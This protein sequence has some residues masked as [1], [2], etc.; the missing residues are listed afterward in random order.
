MNNPRL[1]GRYAKSLLDLAVENNELEKVYADIKYIK[2]LCRQNPDFVSVLKSP[3]IKG[4][5]SYMAKPVAGW[6]VVAAA[7]TKIKV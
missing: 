1:A 2:F 6:A 4:E 3:I 5:K 7:I